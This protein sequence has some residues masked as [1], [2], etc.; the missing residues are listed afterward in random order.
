MQHNINISITRRR[1]VR[2]EFV[3]FLS[4]SALLRDTYCVSINSIEL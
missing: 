3:P 4:V 2:G 1:G